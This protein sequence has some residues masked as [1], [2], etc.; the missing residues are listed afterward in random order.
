[1]KELVFL[2]DREGRDELSSNAGFVRIG[3]EGAALP[4]L[5][6]RFVLPEREAVRTDATVWRG[7]LAL[8]LLCD[9]WPDAGCTVSALTVD[10]TAS[11][12]AAWVLS[13]RPEEKRRDAL[14]LILLQRE[15]QRLLLG[16]A[17][18]HAG[19]TLPATPTDFSGMLP[20]RAVW[21][22][23]DAA[24]WRDPVPYLNADERAILLARLTMMGLDSPEAEAFKADL[25]RAE[26][27]AVDAVLAEDAVAL[28]A[29]SIRMQAIC[30]LNGFDALSV[31][32]EH[33]V[34]QE[35]HPLVRLYSAVDVRYSSRR[36]CFT[37]LWE[38]QP[39]A[40]SSAALGLT[41]ACGA[42]QEALLNAIE[43]E[44]LL[45]SESSVRWNRQCADALSAWLNAQDSALLP[46]VRAEAELLREVQMNRAR[47]V[48][49]TVSLTWPW[50]ASSGAIR[51]LLRESLGEEWLGCASNPFSDRLT[52]LTAHVLGDNALQ[53]GCA[54]ADGVLL[55]PL[56]A[57]LAACLSGAEDGAGLAADMLRF[58][59]REDGGITASF[60]L[61]AQGEVHMTRVYPVE[62]ILVLSQADSPCVAVWPCV[63][64]ERWQAYHVFVR[65]GAVEVDTLRHGEWLT[66][67]APDQ[68]DTPDA[69]SAAVPP[70]QPWRCL[71]TDAYPGC[72]VLHRD[73]QCLGALPN[74]LP[75]LHIEPSADALA[76]ID[77]GSSATAV[78]ILLDGKPISAQAEHLTRL[79][80]SPQDMPSDDFLLSLTPSDITPSSV[81]LIGD[82]DTLFTDGY[83]YAVTHFDAM[84]AVRQGLVCTALKWRRGER[85]VRARKLLLHQVMLGASLT[86]M[87]A[88]AK[89]IRWRVSI[90]DEMG[91]EGRQ[92]LL[93]MAEELSAAVAAQTGLPLSGNAPVAWAEEAVALHA[94]LCA[95]GGMKGTF[96]VLDIG[97]G[98]TKLHLWVQGR[99]LP[100]SG[101]ML[102]MGTSAML[103]HVLF[104][105]PGLL[106]AD[107]ADCG[108]D[109]LISA[110]DA[111]CDQFARAHDHLADADKALLML[112][113]LLD[114]YRQPMTQHLYA[115]FQQQRPTYMQSILLEMYAA[116]M[117][118]IGLML[119]DTGEDSTLSHLFPGDLTVCLTGRGAWLLDTLTPQL[120]NGLQRIAHAPVALRH[121]VRTLTVRPSPLPALGVA[122]GM[123]L[124][125]D[126]GSAADPKPIRTRRSFTELMQSLLHS[127]YQC[128]PAHMWM[129]HPGLFDPAGQLTPAG[130]D[131]VRRLVSQCYGDGEDIPLSVLQFI[132][133]LQ[134]ETLLPT[135][136]FPGE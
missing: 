53:R 105:A 23:A 103:T 11:L 95:E 135:P 5:V 89:S 18:P 35:D 76:A 47:Q 43:P 70:V 99:R 48:Q 127:L 93:D 49:M 45:L 39:F 31:R 72:L 37:Y 33:C 109:G 22:D 10:S 134:R 19:L 50:D 88:G 122:R 78:S 108:S 69:D 13:A 73:G 96:A 92:A 12:F 44:L 86:A 111:L 21:Y 129:L 80:V 133:E 97:G 81:A 15:G 55:P 84:Q 60:L 3:A 121:P 90:A 119:E 100:V 63:P 104:R 128:Y 8:T 42:D 32:E 51:Y 24:V 82:G 115:R 107:F 116:A 74:A 54:C 102:L 65:G 131:T 64:M 114:E 28:R 77:L 20:A 4:D 40:R 101:A 71:H 52:K 38:G 62:E 117:F 136:A 6:S 126:T 120:R 83:V 57:E 26:Q 113:A 56:S 27:S 17:D 41:D 68:P 30:G 110:V 16:I 112:D 125:R 66:L 98:S 94:Y 59:P 1:M 85:F 34:I 132:S 2:P 79:L 46:Q 75:R 14:H 7:I 118:C 58:E 91:D 124:L 87:M 130:E 9:A 29:L 106:R 25:S 67:P 36:A 61:R 123:A